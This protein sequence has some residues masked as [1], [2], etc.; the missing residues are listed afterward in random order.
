V[1]QLAG[2]AEHFCTSESST[3]RRYEPVL[4]AARVL[5]VIRIC[6]TEGCIL[7]LH[8]ATLI[9]SLLAFLRILAAAC[10]HGQR[11]IF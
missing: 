7:T 6:S 8:T 11:R 1:G 2:L 9:L 3:E 4:L 5:A 10:Y